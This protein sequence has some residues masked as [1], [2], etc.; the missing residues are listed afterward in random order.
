MAFEEA[1]AAWLPTQR[2][3]AG[4]GSPVTGVSIASDTTLAEGDPGLRHLVLTVS[5]DAFSDTYQVFAGFRAEI[6][7]RLRHAVIG[8]DGHGM[9]AYDGLHDADLTRLL[10]A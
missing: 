4:K 1:L 10:L 7:Q 3:F 5:Q 2:W 6:P 9:T 8:P